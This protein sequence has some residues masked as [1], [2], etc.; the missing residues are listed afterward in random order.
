MSSKVQP[1]IRE[2]WG[3]ANALTGHSGTSETI[4]ILLELLRRINVRNAGKREGTTTLKEIEELHEEEFR[5]RHLRR[6]ISFRNMREYQDE[7][8]GDEMARMVAEGDDDSDS[9]RRF[10]NFIS[11][12]TTP[13]SKEMLQN[14]NFHSRIHELSKAYHMRDKYDNCYHEARPLHLYEF[15][16]CKMV[17]RTVQTNVLELLAID[18]LLPEM[19]KLPKFIRMRQRLEGEIIDMDSIDEGDA[20]DEASH[21][22][23]QGMFANVLGNFEGFQENKRR[24]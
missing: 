20:R 6:C 12:P 16:K 19:M 2:M 22:V 3:K 14:T 11:E 18:D 5:Q 24:K 8:D 4:K 7:D 23:T 13:R 1:S 9:G 21:L 17:S 10:Q 15:K